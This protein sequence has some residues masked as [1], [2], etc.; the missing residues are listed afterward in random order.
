MLL[1]LYKKYSVRKL[2]TGIDKSL[3]IKYSKHVT[4]LP[5]FKNKLPI[6]WM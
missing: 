5:G 6:F 2:T 3:Q 4:L 1:K